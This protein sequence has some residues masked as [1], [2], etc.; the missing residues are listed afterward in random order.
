LE[1]NLVKNRLALLLDHFSRV[2]DP[3]E[4][5][6]VRYPLREVLFLITCA[7]VAGCDDYDEIADWGE[8]NLAVPEALF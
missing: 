3:R 6:K 2:P 4:P 8:L 5:A 7:S 1:P